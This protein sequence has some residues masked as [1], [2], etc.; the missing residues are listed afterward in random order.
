MVLQ[1]CQWNRLVW[2]ETGLEERSPSSRPSPPRRGRSTTPH[3]EY[4][5]GLHT[6]PTALGVTI[7]QSQDKNAPT[8]QKGDG[9]FSL[10]PGERAGVRADFPVASTLNP[11]HQTQRR[12]K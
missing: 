2:V 3:L 6:R 4:S 12:T 9:C 10:F 5:T 1:C 11:F 8:T 7:H